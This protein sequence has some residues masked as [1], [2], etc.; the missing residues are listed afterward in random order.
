MA[1]IGSWE[2]VVDRKATTVKNSPSL[3]G[4][5]KEWR[6]ERTGQTISIW[7]VEEETPGYPDYYEVRI[8]AEPVEGYSTVSRAY[9]SVIE[10]MKH[11]PHGGI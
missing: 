7:F 8:G 11:F 4:V 9:D 5:V 3:S 10:T 2:K 1:K 6:N